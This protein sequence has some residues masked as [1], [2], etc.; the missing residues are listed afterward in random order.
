MPD[1]VIHEPARLTPVCCTCDLCVIGGS[2]TGVLAALAAARM[3]LSVALVETLGLFG[4]TATASMVCIWHSI[5][6]TTNDRQIAA[7][8]PLELLERLKRID[9][10]SET[11]PPTVHQHYVFNPAEMALELDRMVV[12]ANIRPFLHTRFVAPVMAQPG[13]VSHAI[14]EDKSGRRA[15][16]ADFFID[17]SGDADLAHR[18]GFACYKQPHLQPP[19]ACAI[20]QGLG[21]LKRRQPDFHL[22][23]AAFDP[24]Y[25]EALRPGFLWT[26]PIPHADDMTLVAGT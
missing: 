9:A 6:N 26:A 18:A 12:E 2:T 13:R 25:P 21:A 22:R 3:G 8:L 16:A 10:V 23:E 7:G 15:I 4:G 5:Y 1:P 24:T 17:A 14:I 11:W 20:M 19:T